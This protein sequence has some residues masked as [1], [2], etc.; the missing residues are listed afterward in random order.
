M[1]P[2]DRHAAR[3]RHR[4]QEVDYR[5]RVSA[6]VESDGLEHAA[7]VGDQQQGAVLGVVGHEVLATRRRL[8]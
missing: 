1:E 7:V 6:A 2:G 4:E 5:G 8:R 3:E